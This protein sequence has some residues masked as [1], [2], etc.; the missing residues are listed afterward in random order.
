MVKYDPEYFGMNS[1]T[2]KIRNAVITVLLASAVTTIVTV[3]AGA[4]AFDTYMKIIKGALGSATTTGLVIQSWIPVTLCAC[5]LLFS[6]RIGL[7]NIGVEGQIAMGAIAAS[8]VF[9]MDSG[10]DL[11]M[12]SMIAAA[13][14]SVAGG[15][16]WAFVSGWIRVKSGVN[17]IFT[18]LA[19]NFMVHGL[20][21]W[22]IFGPWKKSGGPSMNGTEILHKDLWLP[23]S[24]SCGIS[25][26]GIAVTLAAVVFT[27]VITGYTKAGLRLEAMRTSPYAAHMY[28]INISSYMLTAIMISG[29]F[30]GLAGFFQLSGICHSI[31]PSISGNYGYLALFVVLFSN[32]NIRVV[33][34]AA[35]LFACINTGAAQLPLTMKID[36]SIAGVIQGCLVISTIAVQT[37][38]SRKINKVK[39]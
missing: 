3:M 18:G 6:F 13:M 17:E 10:A 8:A 38:Y 22:L 4:P 27:A 25:P 34:F 39:V 1:I 20:V 26:A 36:P 7:W 16:G 35:F 33:P 31:T 15:A 9:R 2:G 28:K 5:G 24:D 23:F 29:G 37:W 21:L 32:F 12:A 11:A 30:A 19:M 14:A